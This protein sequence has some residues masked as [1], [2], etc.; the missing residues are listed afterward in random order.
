MVPLVRGEGAVDGTVPEV[1]VAT[2][3][4]LKGE[5]KGSLELESSRP[6]LGALVLDWKQAMQHMRR[7][8][9]GGSRRFVSD[10]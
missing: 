5:K 4:P 3:K 9:L 8:H 6:P 2:A 1:R 10:M 7:L